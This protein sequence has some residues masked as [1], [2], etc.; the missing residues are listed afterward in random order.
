A[1]VLIRS[2][3]LQKASDLLLGEIA[4]QL[5]KQ[6][7]VDLAINSAFNEACAN[8]FKAADDPRQFYESTLLYLAYTSLNSIPLQRQQLIAYDL[9]VAGLIADGMFDFG[10]LIS[11][12][13]LTTLDPSQKW[14]V[15]FIEAASEGSLPMF[16]SAMKQY[17]QQA[18]VSAL[19]GTYSMI[20]SGCIRR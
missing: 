16:E 10:T 3:D 8:Y 15:D 18:N 14:V 6:I 11:A 17:P 2:K 9:A 4:S 19:R 12:P 1:N 20:F 7:G 13:I 5:E